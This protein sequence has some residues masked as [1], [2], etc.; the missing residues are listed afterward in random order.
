MFI[1]MTALA[2]LV[3]IAFM[4]G[5]ISSFIMVVNALARMKGK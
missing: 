1:S 4:L 3:I 2:T 5:M